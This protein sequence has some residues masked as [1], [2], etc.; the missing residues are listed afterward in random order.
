[1]VSLH[2]EQ[3]QRPRVLFAAGP[4]NLAEHSV[5]AAHAFFRGRP[6]VNEHDRGAAQLHVALL[7]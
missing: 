7:K 5:P 1:M 6:A 4:A 2:G 3:T